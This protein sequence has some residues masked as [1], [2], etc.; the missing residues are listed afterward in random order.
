MIAS[1]LGLRRI[2]LDGLRS[3]TLENQ[4]R[5]QRKNRGDWFI[6]KHI[7]IIMMPESMK[8]GSKRKIV[9]TRII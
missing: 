9:R 6:V 7:L 4:R 8:S 2:L 5:L 1:T 3:T